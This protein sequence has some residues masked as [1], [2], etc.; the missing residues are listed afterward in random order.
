[1]LIT[2]YIKGKGIQETR[3]LLIR[4]PGNVQIGPGVEV[5]REGWVVVNCDLERLTKEDGFM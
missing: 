3:V 1:M 2:E 4:T 5:V